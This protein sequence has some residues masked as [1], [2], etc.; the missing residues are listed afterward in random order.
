MKRIDKGGRCSRLEM[1]HDQYC[2]IAIRFFLKV[3]DGDD[4]KW[5]ELVG[6]DGHTW[7]SLVMMIRHWNHLTVGKARG[8]DQLGSSHMAL[9]ERESPGDV[10]NHDDNDYDAED[11]KDL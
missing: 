11:P 3:G 9:M 1:H 7:G 6:D 10:L 4:Q 2:N 8:C 5:D